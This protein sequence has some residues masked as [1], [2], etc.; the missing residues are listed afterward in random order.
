MSTERRTSMRL[1]KDL[2]IVRIQSFLEKA[3]KEFWTVRKV[4]STTTYTDICTFSR[5]LILWPWIAAATYGYAA[6]VFWGALQAFLGNPHLSYL[7][8]IL[9]TIGGILAGV[10]GVIVT[11]IMFPTWIKKWKNDKKEEAPAE[12]TKEVEPSSAEVVWE[13]LKARKAQ[14]CFKIEIVG[15]K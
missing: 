9:V 15:G 7:V 3:T 13:W 11:A 6:W 5:W 8:P 10:I 2:L 4:Y 1:S 14:Y 12:Q